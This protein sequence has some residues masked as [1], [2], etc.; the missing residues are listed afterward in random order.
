MA[1]NVVNGVDV[2]ALGKIISDFKA[3][4]K[5]AAFDFRS[6]TDWHSGAIVNSTF[7]GHKRNGVESTR[8]QPHQLAGDEPQALLGSGQHVG[9]AGHLLHAMCHCLTVTLAY[10]GAARGVRIDSLRV[11]AEGS[12][13][14]QGFLGLSD[15]VKPGFKQIHLKAYIDSPNSSE[16]VL[17]LFQYAQGRSPICST[18]RHNVNIAWEFDIEATDAGPETG[19]DRHGVNFPNLAATVQALTDTPVLGKC[20]FYA[21]EQWLGGAKTRSSHPGF[22]QA[23]GELLMRHREESPKTYVGDEPA[24]LL[25]SDAGPSPSETL[26]HAMANCVSVTTSYHSAARGVPLDAFKVDLEGDMD[27]QGFADL[28]DNVTPAYRNITARVRIRAGGNEREIVELLKFTTS[29]SPMCDSVKRPVDI[30]FSLV[31]NGFAIA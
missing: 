6:S 1:M 24:V 7:T 28:D 31:H 15:K 30:S 19:E 27:L 4:P 20:T 22:D 25:G 13:D 12:L 17:A 5:T 23:E 9:P 14:L 26:L 2:A 16:E 18:V 11:D 8:A 3:D 21:S 10:H 29:H